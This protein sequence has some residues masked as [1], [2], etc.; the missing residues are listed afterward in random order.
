PRQS[1]QVLVLGA[2][3]IGLGITIALKSL[4]VKHVVVADILPSRLKKALEVGA[5]AVINSKEEDVAAR[6]MELHGPGDSLWPNKSGTDV[7]LDAAGVP[8]A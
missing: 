4:G 7:F 8:A 5:D 3:P 2:G 1:D 6:L